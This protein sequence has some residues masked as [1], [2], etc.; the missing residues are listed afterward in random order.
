[1]D[2]KYPD[3]NFIKASSFLY[4]RLALK[5]TLLQPDSCG[6]RR[7]RFLLFKA[8]Q[9]QEL[10]RFINNIRLRRRNAQAFLFFHSDSEMLMV[11][12]DV[13]T[14]ALPDPLKQRAKLPVPA[15]AITF[16]EADLTDNMAAAC[17][18]EPWG[19]LAGL[20]EADVAKDRDGHGVEGQEGPARSRRLRQMLALLAA[21][22]VRPTGLPP[23]CSSGLRHCRASGE[24]G[25]CPS[26]G[27]GVLMAADFDPHTPKQGFFLASQYQTGEVPTTGD[28][29]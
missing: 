26:R 20:T 23:P 14:P 11:K 10:K 13:H 21:P 7:K 1:M 25:C 8:N 28:P 3:S 15:A 16:L 2:H 19:G 29:L 27:G 22:G 17:E 12:V 4:L 5:A 9:Y 24:G 6:G 18:A